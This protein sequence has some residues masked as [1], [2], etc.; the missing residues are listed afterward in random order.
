M[1]LPDA[2]QNQSHETGSS[3]DAKGPRWSRLTNEEIARLTSRIADGDIE[4][5]NTLVQAHLHLV[6]R[7]ASRFA[8]RGLRRD[9]LI[10]E[11]NLGLIRAAEGYDP[12]F[13]TSFSTYATYWIKEAILSAMINTASTIRLPG[14]VSKLLVRWRRTEKAIHLAHGRSP[15]F[16]EVASAMGLDEA[17]QW[18]MARAQVVSQLEME[19]VLS[20]RRSSWTFLM[21]AGCFMP[22]DTLEAQEEQ[23]AVLRRLERLEGRERAV[24]VLRFGL[25]DEAPLSLS[26]VGS[27]LGMTPDAV[28]KLVAAV[29][30]KL[31]G[32]RE[33]RSTPSDAAYVSRVG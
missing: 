31:G 5:R 4:A 10:G 23:A 1:T 22:E 28:R 7:L 29:M 26:D 14:N 15:T 21:L 2:G 33:V 16:E 8:H 9:E 11:G 30:R 27:R 3:R 6:D 24:V 12:A 18:L 17:T 13:G 19:S 32:S 20:N 25:G